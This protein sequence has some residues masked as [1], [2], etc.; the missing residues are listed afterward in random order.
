MKTS[1]SGVAAVLG[2]SVYGIVQVPPESVPLTPVSAPFL[3]SS[4][5]DP[6]AMFVAVAV[7]LT[8]PPE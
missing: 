7:K 5:D 4:T 6:S 1:C 3:N 2:G 8:A